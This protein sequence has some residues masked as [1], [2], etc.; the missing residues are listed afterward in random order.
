MRHG[1]GDRSYVRQNV[2]ATVV[3][4][5]RS[6][7]RS[8]KAVTGLVLRVLCFGSQMSKMHRWCVHL[9]AEESMSLVG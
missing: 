2:V 3:Y 6:G 5:P 7:E 9:E 4:L 1:L 8:Y